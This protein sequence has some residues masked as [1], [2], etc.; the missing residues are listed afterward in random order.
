M[1]T[2]F[3]LSISATALIGLAVTP[4]LAQ[5]TAT[6]GQRLERLE[7]QFSEILRQLQENNHRTR[8]FEA[9]LRRLRDEQNRLLQGTQEQVAVAAAAPQ[10]AQSA[11]DPG[12]SEHGPSV[13]VQPASA[14]RPPAVTL[15]VASIESDPAE[16]AYDQGYKLWRAGSYGQALTALRTVA[17]SF[18]SHRRASWA[19]NLTGRALL[20]KG[21]PRAAAQVLLANYRADPSGERAA[22]SLYYLGQALVRIGHPREACA[23]YAELEAVYGAKMRDELKTLLPGAKAQACG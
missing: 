17:S 6:P 1:T 2:L 16:V 10:I 4:A 13:S 19:R 15:A 23:A 11:S 12:L 18:P 21:E 3:R 20:D 14:T 5:R 22:D 9:E 7:R 8:E